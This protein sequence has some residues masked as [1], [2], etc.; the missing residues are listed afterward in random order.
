MFSLNNL[1]QCFFN[2]IHLIK[3]ISHHKE[4]YYKN[5]INNIISIDEISITHFEQSKYGWS[6]KN[7]QC[8]IDIGNLNN[9]KIKSKRYSVLMATS[10]K[11]IINYTIV[12]NGIKKEQ[13][14][15]F[16]KNMKL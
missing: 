16:M 12:E 7:T 10:N 1:F 9:G 5:K 4:K 3:Q 14:L 2:T 13:F 11:K 8:S 6:L 15:K